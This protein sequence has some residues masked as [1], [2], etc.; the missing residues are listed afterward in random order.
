ML[1][2]ILSLLIGYAFGNF[3]TA[4]ILIRKMTGQSPYGYGTHNPGMANVMAHCGFAYG[5]LVL[6]GDLL[7]TAAACLLAY[8]LFKNDPG[9][10]AVLYAGT[11]AVLGHNFP[12]WKNFRGGL[13]VA[14]TCMAVF[15]FSPLWGL[16]ADA[17]GMLV[18]FATQYLPLGA[19]AIP[20][21][22]MIPAFVFYGTEAGMLALFLTLLM[23]NRHWP[24]V[25][26]VIR[27][28]AAKTDVLGRIRKL[29]I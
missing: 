1:N 28:T 3:I 17:G 24:G 8:F 16:L 10:V 21:L 13:G 25:T 22:F 9:P 6:A 11:G 23:L 27:G 12:F 7:K 4:E 15:C 18:V 26:A 29:F 2:R 19:V 14:C 20:A 5:I